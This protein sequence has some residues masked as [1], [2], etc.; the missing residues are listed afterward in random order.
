MNARDEIELALARF[1]RR[2]ADPKASAAQL[3][4]Q[5]DAARRAEALTEGA[6][7]IAD[8]ERRNAWPVRPVDAGICSEFLRGMA[9][10]EKS[11]READATPAP[12]VYRASHESIPMGLYTTAAEARAHC[13]AEERRTWAKGTALVFDWIEDAE[14][15][16]VAEL[17][18]VAED[19]EIETFTGYVVTA[20]EV[21]SKYDPEADE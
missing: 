1:F 20:L 8:M 21:A 18:T 4:A 5:Y 12:I 3:L 7:A 14:E 17:V 2:D 10:G 19:G 11:S 9:A 15:D 13:V 6:D 16:G